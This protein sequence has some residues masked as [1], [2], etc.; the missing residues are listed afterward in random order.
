MNFRTCPISASGAQPGNAFWDVC[1]VGFTPRPALRPSEYRRLG[2]CGI[3]L[4]D[5]VKAM[6]VPIAACPQ[7]PIVEMS[8]SAR[9]EECS[10]GLAFN[11]KKAAS[12]FFDRSTKAITDG[13]QAQLIGTTSIWVLPSTS[14]AARKYWCC[15]PWSLR[16]LTSRLFL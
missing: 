9:S 15:G 7:P 16:G 1:D 10:R 5:L 2:E 14:A 11:G 12:L 13:R 8:S 3:G 4:T 6:R